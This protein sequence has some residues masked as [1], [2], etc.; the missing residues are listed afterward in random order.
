MRHTVKKTLPARTIVADSAAASTLSRRSRRPDGARGN[1]RAR[2][3][4]RAHR[5]ES[6]AK[7]AF[8]LCCRSRNWILATPAAARDGAIVSEFPKPELSRVVR[9]HVTRGNLN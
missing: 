6:L 7:A 5:N 2:S 1:V 9:E 4:R 8:L 3:N